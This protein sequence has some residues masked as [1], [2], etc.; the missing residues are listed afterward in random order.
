MKIDFKDDFNTRILSRGYEYNGTVVYN[1]F[2]IN[3]TGNS[4][5]EIIENAA[6]YAYEHEW[7]S[8]EKG[9]LGGIEF[10]KEGYI[11][12]GQNTLY[13]QKFDI[14]NQDGELYSNQYMQN[15]LAP[16]SE[17]SNMLEI[18]EAS[19][20]VDTNLNFIIPLYENMPQDVSER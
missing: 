16:M 10:V 1:P 2:N 15:L 20:T 17:A 13:L 3:A 18:Y 8:L 19:N 7:D 9:L 5:Q 4:S 11:N 6:Q 12:K 14:V